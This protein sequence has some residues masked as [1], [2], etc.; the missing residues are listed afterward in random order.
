MNIVYENYRLEPEDKRFNLYK[1]RP[2]VDKKTG[3]ERVSEISLGYGMTFENCIDTIS[4]DILSD[5]KGNVSFDEWI[6]QYK[7]ITG[8]ISNILK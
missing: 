2:V 8:K 6:K 5:K 4:K 1:S 3:K 7:E